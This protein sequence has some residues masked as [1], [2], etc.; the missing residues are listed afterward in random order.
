MRLVDEAVPHAPPA[1]AGNP[2]QVAWRNY[3][4]TVLK[5]GYMYKLSISPSVILYVCE[6]K[7]LAGKENKGHEGEA[8]GRKLSIAFFEDAP[9]PGGL[10]QR[11]NRE[12]LALSPQLLTIAEILQTCGFI[13]P[14]DPERSASTSELLL[15]EQY[16]H[17]ELERF[18]CTVEVAAPQVHMY[19]LSPGHNAEAALACEV[20]PEQRTKIMLSRCLERNEALEEGETLQAAW[21]KSLLALQARAAPYLPAPLAPPAPPRGRGRGRGRGGGRGAPPAPPLPAPA[22]PPPPPPAPPD[23]R[24]RGKGKGNGR[25]R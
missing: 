11:V 15:E 16:L 2:F 21:S 12:S 23:P 13:L 10:V 20:P 14:P 4:K 9:G 7:T 8:M 6:N 24:G 1:L 22:V 19:S 5:K 17:L 25:G 3:L 18:E